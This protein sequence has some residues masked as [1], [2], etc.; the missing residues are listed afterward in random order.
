MAVDISTE[1]IQIAGRQRLEI[2]P[3]RKII[4]FIY[5]TN[6]TEISE[7][8]FRADITA[9]Y[10]SSIEEV[11]YKNNATGRIKEREISNIKKIQAIEKYGE[12]Y[13]MWSDINQ[14]FTINQIAYIN[15]QYCYDV[16]QLNYRNGITI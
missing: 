16:Q 4:T 9:K 8:D 3:F 2:N 11:H 12:S 5:K 1:L 15:E 14:C 7:D 13:A 10:E 6:I